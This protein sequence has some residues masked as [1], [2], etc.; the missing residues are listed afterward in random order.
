M[1]KE[2]LIAKLEEEFNWVQ[3]KFEEVITLINDGDL[4]EKVGETQA[5]LLLNQESAMQLYL[6]TLAMRMDD[7]Q[8]SFD[9]EKEEQKK[10]ADKEGKKPSKKPSPKEEEERAPEFIKDLASLMEKY[11]REEK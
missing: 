11:I 6:S 7:L 9:E 3:K 10:C 5:N 4:E 8:D 1:E 2:K